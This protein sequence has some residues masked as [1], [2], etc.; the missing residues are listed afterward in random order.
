MIQ[1]EDQKGC[2]IGIEAINNKYNEIRLGSLFLRNF[3]VGLDYRYNSIAIVQNK[4]SR[5]G[6]IVGSSPNP[7]EKKLDPYPNK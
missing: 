5:D 6:Y 3:Y 4:N 7:N 2:Y 1:A